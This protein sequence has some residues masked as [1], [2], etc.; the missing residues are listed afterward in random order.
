MRSSKITSLVLLLATSVTASPAPP[1]SP[2]PSSPPS[3]PPPSL[4]RFTNPRVRQG[5]IQVIIDKNQTLEPAIQGPFPDPGIIHASDGKWYAFSTQ[6]PNGN[7][8]MAVADTPLGEW[9]M[10]DKDA[11]P[12]DG[13]TSGK[14]FWA[15]DVRKLIDGTYIMYFSGRVPDSSHCIGVSRSN[16]VTG[17]YKPD[18]KPFACPLKDGGAID[19]A[20]FY[21]EAT[22]KR[23]VMYKVDGN[24]IGNGGTCGNTVEPI[25][26]TPI[27]LQQ[28]SPIDGSTPIGRPTW[29]LNVDPELDGPL[30]EAPN[31]VYVAGTYVLFF[32]TGCYSGDGYKTK[33]AY[34]SNVEGPYV[35]ANETLLESPDLGLVGPGGATSTEDGTLVLALHGYCGE[36]RCMY[37]VEYSV[38]S[39]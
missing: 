26:D 19:P 18:P 37:V 3:S 12:D 15:P 30:V 7:V 32:S 10:L 33:Y 20:G 39:S 1:L 17:P 25:V 34:S 4:L 21:D 23:Y 35:R 16:K 5:D 31:I 22:G 8:P 11:M 2:P 9:T 13:W 24:A 14:D 27:L 6:G 29:I 36:T 28:V 38:E